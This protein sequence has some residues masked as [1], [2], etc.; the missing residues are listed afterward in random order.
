MSWRIVWPLFMNSRS[1]TLPWNSPRPSLS[2]TKAFDVYASKAPG[3]AGGFSLL[4]ATA[5]SNPVATLKAFTVSSAVRA[6]TR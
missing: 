4:A 5:A 1:L 3:S 2:D 6:R